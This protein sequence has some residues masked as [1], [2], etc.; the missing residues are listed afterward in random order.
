MRF[1]YM[2]DTHFGVYDQAVPTPREASRAFQ[3]L[4]DEAETA[5]RVGF[6]GIFLPERHGRTETFAPS[7]LSVAT[8]IAARTTRITI[9]TTVVMPAL[10]NPMHL[11]E[12]IS[13]IDNLSKGRFIFGAGVGYHQGYHQTFGVPWE[14]RGKRFEEAMEVIV[15]ALTEDRFSFH[16]EFYRYD[17]V[18]LTPKPYQRPR[19]PIWIGAHAEGKPVDRSLDYDGWVLWTLPAWEHTA[20]WVADM[21][22]RAAERGK[23][24]WTVVL[25]QDGW[26]GDDAAAVRARHSPRWLREARFYEEHD[27]PA[28]IDPS[29]DI[30]QVEGAEKALREFETRQMHFGTPESWVERISVI[31]DTLAPDWLN[32]RTRGPAAEYGPPYP[33]FEESIEAIERFGEE[34]IRRFR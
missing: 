13:M 7:S 28:E 30:S 5:E 15:R 33:T 23:P 18:Q 1:A 24:N 19:P 25:D 11:A 14:R 9:A 12:Q 27:F 3:H 2:P 8:A 16:G 21:R 10:Y 29:G 26:I 17:D 20:K 31:R 34:V 32:I 22:R 6:D 4:L